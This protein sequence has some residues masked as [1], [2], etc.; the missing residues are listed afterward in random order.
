MKISTWRR[1]EGEGSIKKGDRE[2]STRGKHYAVS[3]FDSLNS[4]RKTKY[5]IDEDES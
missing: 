5:A 1:G 2:G 4:S 3:F